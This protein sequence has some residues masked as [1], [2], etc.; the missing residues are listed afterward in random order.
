MYPAAVDTVQ[1]PR[2]ILVNMGDVS[3]VFGYG[4]KLERQTPAGWRWINRSQAV[5]LVLL[6]LKPGESSGPE[7]IGIYRTN[8]NAS[9]CPRSSEPCCLR[10]VLRPGLYRVTKGVSFGQR[11]LT[12]RT[13]FRVF[14]KRTGTAE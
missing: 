8:P 5:P 4:Y 3:V 6:F 2:A 9:R 7:R 14:D 1:A 12:V 13:T 10:V 11:H